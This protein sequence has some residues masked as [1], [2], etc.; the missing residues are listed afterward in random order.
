MPGIEGMVGPTDSAVL[1]RI[2]FAG[3]FINIHLDYPNSDTDRDAENHNCHPHPLNTHL[4]VPLLF[5]G[6]TRSSY[7]WVFLE[8][9]TVT[10]V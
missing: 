2:P 4:R 8:P 7:V 9:R 1:H 10:R 5:T 6:A 3:L